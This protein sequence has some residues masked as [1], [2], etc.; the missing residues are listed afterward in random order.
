MK[1]VVTN[2]LQE[3][4]KKDCPPELKSSMLGLITSMNSQDMSKT[5]YESMKKLKK[6]DE[7]RGES[8]IEVFPEFKEMAL[9]YGY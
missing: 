5:L 2:Y 9:K 3:L 8:F 1:E 4:W 6:V 7:V